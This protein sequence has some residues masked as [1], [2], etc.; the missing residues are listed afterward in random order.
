MGGHKERAGSRGRR[1]EKKHPELLQTHWAWKGQRTSKSPHRQASSQ[2]EA[3]RLPSCDSGLGLGPLLDSSNTTRGCQQDKQLAP[4]AAAALDPRLCSTG[5]NQSHV[6]PLVPPG[7]RGC[8][9]QGI[10]KLADP[11]PAL[12]DASSGTGSTFGLHW[13]LCMARE[14]CVTTLPQVFPVMALKTAPSFPSLCRGSHQ[15]QP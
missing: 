15:G 14:Q 13:P 9:A 10:E 2:S 6:G 8:G 1:E 5:R 3:V 11:R 7:L 4:E 12:G